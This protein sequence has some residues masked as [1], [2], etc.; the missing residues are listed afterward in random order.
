MKEPIISVNTLAFQ[1]YDLSVAV[2]ALAELNIKYVEF[3]FIKGY[4]EGM[5]ESSFSPQSAKYIYDLI[6][7]YG[8]KTAA[9]AAHMDLGMQ[10]SVEAFKRRMD[11]AALLGVSIIL[12]NASTREN[13]V[14]FLR[15][16]EKLAAYAESLN[17]M[18]GLE[19]PGDGEN[20][21]IGT[22]QEGAKLIKEIDSPFIRLNYDVGNAYSY[23][24]GRTRPEDDIHYAYPYAFYLHFKDTRA[25]GDGWIFTEIGKGVINYKEVIQFMKGQPEQLAIGLELPLS[26]RRDKDFSPQKKTAPPSLADIKN[27]VKQSYEYTV[28]AFSNTAA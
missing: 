11:F 20:N 19:N 23:S 3:A 4:S 10:D 7:S 17:L 25:D 15:N 2:K 1:G 18:I 24:K 5:S 27:A 13:R 14:N 16:I 6:D 12:S 22:G 8:L 21:L 26:V 9:L 28:A